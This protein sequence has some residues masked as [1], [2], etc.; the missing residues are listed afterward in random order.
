MIEIGWFLFKQT[1]LTSIYPIFNS[2]NFH[3]LT[4]L[5]SSYFCL[6]H[7]SLFYLKIFLKCLLQH[8]AFQIIIIMFLLIN[9]LGF[10][11]ADN[12]TG[13][14]ETFQSERSSMYWWIGFKTTVWY[15][16]EHHYSWFTCVFC[17]FLVIRYYPRM[18]TACSDCWVFPGYHP[19]LVTNKNGGISQMTLK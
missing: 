12:T 11:Y 5:W 18:N 1:Y 17:L 3:H 10:T 9:A 8:L 7:F 19:C 16:Y 2:S 15:H 14:L 13:V 4:F 6:I